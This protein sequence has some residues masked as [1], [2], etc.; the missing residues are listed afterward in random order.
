[1]ILPVET[2]L[3][4]FKKLDPARLK[5]LRKRF[6]GLELSTPRQGL[7]HFV[8]RYKLVAQRV[9]RVEEVTQSKPQNVRVRSGFSNKLTG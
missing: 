3:S 4:T 6:D 5:I 7:V 9:R 1:M 2:F 8:A